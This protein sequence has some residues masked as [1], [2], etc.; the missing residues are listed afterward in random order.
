VLAVTQG[1][2]VLLLGQDRLVAPLAF[3]AP[4]LCLLLGA[5]AARLVTLAR[6]RGGEWA[7][8]G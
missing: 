2:P 7:R 6:L 8:T 1:A 4:A 3:V 5:G